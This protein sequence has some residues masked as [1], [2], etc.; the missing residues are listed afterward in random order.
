MRVVGQRI[1]SIEKAFK[2][3]NKYTFPY[4]NHPHPNLLPRAGEGAKVKKLRTLIYGKN[5]RLRESNRKNA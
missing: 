2:A 1:R 4:W 5:S 3:P